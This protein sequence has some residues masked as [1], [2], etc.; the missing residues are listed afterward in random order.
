[1]GDPDRRVGRVHA[2]PSRPGRGRG[3]DLEVLLGQL[4]LDLVRFRQHR[5]RRRRGVDAPLALGLRHPLYAVDTGLELELGVGALAVDL[6]LDP[7]E[8]SDPRLLEVDHLDPPAL[9]VGP[10]GVHPEEVGREQGRLLAALRGL[11][12]HHHVAG[13][14]RVPGEEQDP[15][16]V[17][18]GTH[19]LLGGVVL[20]SEELLHLRVALLAEQL[21]GLLQ[22]PLGPAIVVV[23]AHQLLQLVQLAAQPGQ[24]RRVGD[25]LGL[26]HLLL[27]VAVARHQGLQ[28]VDHLAASI[29]GWTSPSRAAFRAMIATSSM[30]SSGSRVVSRCVA[31][32]GR[33]AIR[34]SGWW[35]C[36]AMNRMHSK[37]RLAITPTPTTLDA[38]TQGRSGWAT[39]TRLNTSTLTTRTTSK[40][41]VPQRGCRTLASRAWGTSRGSPT[42]KALIALCSAPWY[43]KTR[44]TSGR[45]PTRS[46]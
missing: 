33:S 27:E 19:P 32:T 21:P 16:A 36:P 22:L 40:K 2:L 18:E 28:P 41:P 8:T 25:H 45:S 1:M 37:L 34:I 29:V 31:S 10:A 43:W 30:S 15:E 9:G 46:R 23:D 13:V 26:R 38:T 42:S 7:V 24:P 12:L 6:E 3:L 17:L 35:R 11:D 5:H 4:D 20:P 44:R 39:A 14:V